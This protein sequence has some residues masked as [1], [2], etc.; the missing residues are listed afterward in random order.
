ML[1]PVGLPELV[2]RKAT[3]GFFQ[4]MEDVLAGAERVGAEIRAGAIGDAWLE[5]AKGNTIAFAAGAVGNGVIGPRAV[6]VGG[7]D[8]H[9]FD[10]RPFGAVRQSPGYKVVLAQALNRDARLGRGRKPQ[11]QLLFEDQREGGSDMLARLEALAATPMESFAG[12]VHDLDGDDERLAVFCML[13]EPQ[14]ELRCTQIHMFFDLDV[15]EVS[16]RLNE[17][18]ARGTENF[19]GIDKGEPREPIFEG[20]LAAGTGGG[21]GCRH[22]LRLL[23]DS[24]K[25][26]SSGNDLLRHV[27]LC[28]QAAG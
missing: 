9:L 5:A 14:A 25:P 13:G 28:G 15:P 12:L 22:D 21:D 4:D 11:G 7:A 3:F 2:G 27:R 8:R 20:Q 1:A 24:R 18:G 19:A 17:L 6:G 26:W 16:A 10:P 23:R